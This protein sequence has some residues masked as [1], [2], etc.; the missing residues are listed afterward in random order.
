MV[1]FRPG[2]GPRSHGSGSCVSGRDLPGT[3]GI[4]EWYR[5]RDPGFLEAQGKAERGAAGGFAGGVNFSAHHFHQALYDCQTE[6]GAA[7]LSCDRD[8][9]LLEAFKE[10]RESLPT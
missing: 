7:V 3:G 2:M 6:A 8:V 4:L 5:S 9:G 10:M 1:G